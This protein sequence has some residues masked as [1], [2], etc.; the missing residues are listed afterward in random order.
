MS[1]AVRLAAITPANSAAAVTLPF[2]ALPDNA[3]CSVSGAMRTRPSATAS[4]AVTGL[5]PTSTM[6]A[7][8]LL[9]RCVSS[10]ISVPEP[11]SCRARFRLVGLLAPRIV[12]CPRLDPARARRTGY[13][14]PQGR[15]GFQIVH[16]HF[17]RLE[18]I[19][20]MGPQRRDQDN[21]LA[22]PDHPDAVDHQ[23]IR[24]GKTRRHIPGD[25]GDLLFRE[26]FILVQPQFRDRLAL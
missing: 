23:K 21:R 13:L 3:F 5:S 24:A 10:P 9:S 16:Q 1:S 17:H 18:G 6:R 11:R 12:L 20:A 26:A 15:I 7:C 8:P 22:R 14:L 4:R 25:T 19:G 2:L